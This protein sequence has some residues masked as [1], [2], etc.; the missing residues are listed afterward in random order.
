VSW[1]KKSKFG[2]IKVFQH[3]RNWPSKLELAVYETLLLMERGGKLAEIECQVK[4][5]FRTFDHG[6]INMIPDFAAMDLANN[7]KIYIEAKGFP[8]QE[9][10]RKKKAW[11]VG[12][13]GKL[14]VYTGNW[15]YPKC[16]E[17]VIPKGEKAA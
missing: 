13:P 4:V 14:Y 9:W 1:A 2:A 10:R 15:R 16:T 7:E 8:T 12:G 17:I 5:R 11:G 3:G 6:L